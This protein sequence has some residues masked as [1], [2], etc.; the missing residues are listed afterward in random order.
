M[1][2]PSTPKAKAQIEPITPRDLFACAALAG[3]LSDPNCVGLQEDIAQEC[4]KFADAML[5]FRDKK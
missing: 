4:F 3:L 1:K 2:P 5:A